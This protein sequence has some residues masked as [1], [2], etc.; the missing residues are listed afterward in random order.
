MNTLN[1]KQ[2]THDPTVRER[3]NQL[4]VTHLTLVASGRGRGVAISQLRT[5]PTAARY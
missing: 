3:L 5:N 4:K 1:N 2:I